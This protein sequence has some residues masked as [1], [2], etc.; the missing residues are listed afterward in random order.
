MIS[1]EILG[2]PE[3]L[4]PQQL[5]GKAEWVKIFQDL[6]GVIDSAGLCLFTSFALGLDDYKDLINAALGWNL[7]S[8]ELLKI[9]ER[10]W[11]LERKFNLEA[12]ISPSEDTLPK[13]LLEDP[14]KEGPNKGQVVHLDVLLPKYYE[15]RGWSK[16]GIPTQD[17]LKE[18]E[19]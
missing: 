14:V 9:G 16:E 5:E 12:G 10:I 3:K 8:E 2:V 4:D 17:K 7:T 6:T 19:I 11:N 13:R 1:P 18:L 15:V